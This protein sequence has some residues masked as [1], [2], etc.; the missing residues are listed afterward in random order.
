MGPNQTLWADCQGLTLTPQGCQGL[1]KEEERGLG[2]VPARWAAQH[3]GP[4][5]LEEVAQRCFSF[6]PL[7][8]SYFPPVHLPWSFSRN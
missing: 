3:K 8:E 2:V 6:C 4:G 7:P 5:Q 1:V